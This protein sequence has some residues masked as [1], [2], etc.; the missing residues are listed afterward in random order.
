MKKSKKPAE[1]NEESSV[2]KRNGATPAEDLYGTSATRHRSLQDDL[3]SGRKR[4][5]NH[6]SKRFHGEGIRKKDKAE[7]E[8]SVIALLFMFKWACILALGLAGVFLLRFH[9]DNL[10]EGTKDQLKDAQARIAE[11]EQQMA[12]SPAVAIGSTAR[13]PFMIEKW[14]AAINEIDY[15]VNMKKWDSDASRAE[16]DRRLKS[17]IT[18]LPDYAYARK[19]LA[20]ANL[21]AADPADA[22]PFIIQ[23]LNADPADKDLQ[24]MLAQTYSKLNDDRSVRLVADWY[25]ESYPSDVS[26]L[27]MASAAKMNLGK[28]EEAKKNFD[29][30]LSINARDTYA[31]DGL[32]S[33]YFD[34]E[35]Y[36]AATPL[37]EKLIVLKPE[38]PL[39]YLRLAIGHAKADNPIQ[40]V[41][42]LEKAAANIGEPI[43]R[44]WIV[45]PEFDGIRNYHLF[46]GFNA[47]INKEAFS[48]E[49]FE[50]QQESEEQRKAKSAQQELI[51]LE[52]QLFKR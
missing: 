26:M 3:L 38:T 33:I 17:A 1:H 6:D 44:S 11:L 42:I 36:K 13:L 48:K 45:L 14:N 23:A 16:R 30:L 39:Y 12:V 51:K 25:L 49:A 8:R 37:Y 46:A 32:A 22:I 9:L 28:K 43:V 35:N 40:S 15:V 31:L 18:L 34:R 41:V 47:R 2:K 7:L 20:D 21:N 5:K 50:Q 27:R 4:K 52:E 24:I 29:Q 19:L 10:N